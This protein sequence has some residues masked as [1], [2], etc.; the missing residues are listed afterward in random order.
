[1]KFY[2]FNQTTIEVARN[3]APSQPKVIRHRVQR[4]ET[5]IEIARRYGASAERILKM[6]NI[7]RANLIRAGSTLLVPRF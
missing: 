5:L 2:D 1:M 7:R 4:G 3:Y 6:N